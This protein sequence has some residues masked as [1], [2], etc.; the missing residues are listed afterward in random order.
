MAPL[1]ETT[2]AGDEDVRTAVFERKEEEARPL[3]RQA[4]SVPA[5]EHEEDAHCDRHE[6]D[7]RRDPLEGHWQKVSSCTRQTPSPVQTNP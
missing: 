7:D 1:R 5:L 6:D 2:L 3:E 4:R